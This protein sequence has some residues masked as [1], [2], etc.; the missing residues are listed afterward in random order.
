M[1]RPENFDIS[2]IGAGP[3]GSVLGA[4]LAK[5]GWSVAIIEKS[6]FHQHRIG[7]HLSPK[8][9]ALI[10]SLGLGH[11]LHQEKHLKSTRVRSYWGQEEASFQDYFMSPFGSGWNLDRKQF[12]AD[13]AAEAQKQGASLKTNT[14]VQEVYFDG[15]LNLWRINTINASKTQ[16]SL[17]SQWLVDATGRSAF[18]ANKLGI[19][20][21]RI[22]KLVGV[23]GYFEADEATYDSWSTNLILESV[24]S[25]WWYGLKLPAGKILT[26]F[27]SDSDIAQHRLTTDKCAN[28]M[29]L[30]NSTKLGKQIPNKLSPILKTF[31]A[32]SGY[33]AQ[34]SGKQWLAVGEAAVSFDPLASRG[35]GFA[36]QTAVKAADTLNS[37]RGEPKNSQQSLQD[38]SQFLN[39]QWHIYL[40]QRPDIFQAENRWPDSPFWARRH[41]Y[42][43]SLLQSSVSNDEVVS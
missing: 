23:A 9:N 41:Q 1:K 16:Q 4:L 10:N 43:Q 15:A 29:A 37:L 13:L 26:V 14:Q 12:D 27:L 28:W 22:D 17:Q 8:G 19:K 5:S 24:E 34:F 2:I 35:I 30:L 42:K 11:I 31:A 39:E 38:Y 3:A 25:G 40:N 20:R 21:N 7:E 6:E 18:I 32:D 33:L 36:L